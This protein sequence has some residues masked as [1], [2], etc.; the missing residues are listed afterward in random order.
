LAGAADADRLFSLEY[1]EE[2]RAFV[3]KAVNRV[4]RH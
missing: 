2:T 1:W 4:A 3:A